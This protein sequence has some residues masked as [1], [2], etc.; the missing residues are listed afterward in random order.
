ML[1]ALE[2]EPAGFGFPFGPDGQAQLPGLPCWPRRTRFPTLQP[3]NNGTRRLLRVARENYAYVVV[4]AG[5]HSIEMYET[6]FEMASTVYLVTQVSVAEL[7]NANRFVSRYFRGAEGRQTRD[8]PESVCSRGTSKS[9]RP[10]SPK[11]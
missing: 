6:L 9:M 5:S 3:S 10:P 1:D 4:D 8:R 2:N 11:R 7:R